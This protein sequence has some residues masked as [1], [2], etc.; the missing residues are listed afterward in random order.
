MYDMGLIIHMD[1]LI[2]LFLLPAY[3]IGWGI[4]I[5]IWWFIL[6]G[7]WTVLNEAYASYSAKAREK[8]KDHL[9]D[10]DNYH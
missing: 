1:W 3:I 2:T 8:R 10:I 5:I 4:S 9:D 6:S 7:A